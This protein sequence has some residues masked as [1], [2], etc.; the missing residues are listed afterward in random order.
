[1]AE[2]M[3]PADDNFTSSL[4]SKNITVEGRRTSVR[5]EPEMW[6]A[7]NEISIRERCSIHDLCSLVSQ[8]KGQAS[9]LTASIRVFLMLY[10]RSA[11]TEEGHRRAGH[12]D[13]QAMQ[14]R[15]SRI[16]RQNISYDQERYEPNPRYVRDS[17]LAKGFERGHEVTVQSPFRN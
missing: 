2:T 12:G 8:R 16:K 3:K 14:D 7:L 6:L 13:F 17:A 9:S 4:V 1:M 15:A 11:T 10:Y 5:L